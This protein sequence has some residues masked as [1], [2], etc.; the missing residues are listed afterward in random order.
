MGIRNSG[1]PP[2]PT[3]VLVLTDGVPFMNDEESSR[4]K[5]EALEKGGEANK[6]YGD[7][8]QELEKV[9]E[10]KAYQKMVDFSKECAEK[11]LTENDINFTFVRVGQDPAAHE[12]LTRLDKLPD[13]KLD[14]IT[15]KT[16]DGLM[17]DMQQLQSLLS[18]KRKGSTGV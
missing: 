16:Y 2:A 10:Q 15:Y 12:F 5:K 4:L 18:L 17:T 13:V 3:S 8:V 14:C 7:Y 1:N 11:G 6:K 9:H